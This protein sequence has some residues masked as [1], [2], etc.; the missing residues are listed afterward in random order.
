MSEK[1]LGIRKVKTWYGL[2]WGVVDLTAEFGSDV[3]ETKKRIGLFSYDEEGLNEA[4]EFRELLEVE[5]S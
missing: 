1:Q 3:V 4:R 2:K 5:R